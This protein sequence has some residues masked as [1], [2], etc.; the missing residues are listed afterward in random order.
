MTTIAPAERDA[1]DAA[2]LPGLLTAIREF[3]ARARHPAGARAAAARVPRHAP[4]SWR[5][6]ARRSARTGLWAPFLPTSLG[7]LGLSLVEYAEVSAVLGTTPAGH[8][9]F[10]CQAPDVGN[11]E[12]LHAHGIAGAA[13][14]ATSRRSLRGEI[15]SCFSMTEPEHAGLEPRVDGHARRAAT[16][17]TTSSRAQV[18]HVERR[19]RRVRD[20]HGGD[21]SRAHRRIAA[22][23]RSSCRSTRPGVH[24]R[25]QHRG[26]WARRASDWASHAE[27]AL[28]GRARAGDEPHRRRRAAASRSRRSGSARAASTTACAGS[29]SASARS[30]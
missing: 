11:M 29:A 9:V 5:R 16:A 18:V 17:T 26:S 13:A 21:R 3:L 25:A 30:T 8:Y 19:R 6:C 28:R 24:A 4:R 27:I 20:R 23:R 2:R 10:N 1:T 12:L 14:R 22:R 15:R 7:G